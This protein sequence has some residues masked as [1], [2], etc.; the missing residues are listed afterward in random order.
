MSSTLSGKMNCLLMLGLLLICCHA[1]IIEVD[2]PLLTLDLQA[3]N[4]VVKFLEDFKE[5]MRTGDEALGIPVLD[6]FFQSELPI[7]IKEDIITLDALLTNLNVNKLSEYDVL[8]GNFGIIGLKFNMN[9]SW[10]QISASTNYSMTGNVD[11]FQIYGKGKIDM[12][13]HDFVFGT[14]IRFKVSGIHLKVKAVKSTVSLKKLNFV[15][16]G[17][18]NDEEASELIS[19]IVSSVV[20]ELIDNYQDTI[21]EKINALIT[22]ELDAFLADKTISDLLKMFG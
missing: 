14:E 2:D 8:S 13:A 15:A 12:S 5:K 6:P 1:R 7:K 18:F 20:P 10:P 9:L 3:S 11:T 21:T 16:T 22:K 4:K 17:I 19:S